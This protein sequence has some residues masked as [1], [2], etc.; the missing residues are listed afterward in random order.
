MSWKSG[1]LSTVCFWSRDVIG[2]SRVLKIN[3][4]INNLMENFVSVECLMLIN[5]V[6]D[7]YE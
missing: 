7:C 4:E 2:G 6:P 3:N 5:V 1:A